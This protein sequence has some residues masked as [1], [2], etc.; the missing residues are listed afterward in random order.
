MPP[1]R[2]FLAFLCGLLLALTCALTVLTALIDGLGGSAPL[3]LSLMQRHAPSASTGL[4]QEQ[5]PAMAEMITDY[6]SGREHAFQFTFAQDGADYVCFHENEQQHMADCKALFNLDRAVLML[7]AFAAALLWGGAYALRCFKRQVA[8]G[9]LWGCLMPIAAVAGLILWGAV[10][11]DGL[12]VLFHRLSFA[13]DLW[14]LNPQT[15]LLIRLMPTSF[16]VHYAVLLG[17]TWLGLLLLMGAAAWRLT[18]R[19]KP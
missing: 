17:G 15:D 9:A 10:D 7:A 1:Y 12:F 4:P 5:Y 14:L 2:R 8:R 11:F 16:F 19:W 18:A 6:L 13:N 3:M